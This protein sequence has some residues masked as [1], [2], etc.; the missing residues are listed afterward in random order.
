M[1]IRTA[2]A[3]CR[4]YALESRNVDT[5]FMNGKGDNLKTRT[6]IKKNHSKLRMKRLG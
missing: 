1:Y 2:G 6:Q 4:T 3:M 5:C